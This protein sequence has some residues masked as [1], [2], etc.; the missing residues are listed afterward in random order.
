MKFNLINEREYERRLEEITYHHQLGIDNKFKVQYSLPILNRV[1]ENFEVFPPTP[2]TRRLKEGNCYANS[3][4]KM[5]KGFQY[6]EGVIT[7]KESNLQISHAWNIDSDGKHIDFTIME[8]QRFEYKGVII[9]PSTLYKVGSKN[10][11]V[12]Y[13][14]L[15]Y[16]EVTLPK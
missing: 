4:S 8:T 16:L 12:W 11:N 13:C 5:Q 10:G 7:D 6:V 1:G 15:P 14:C 2:K 3:I 9:P